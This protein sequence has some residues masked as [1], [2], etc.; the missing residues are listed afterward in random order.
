MCVVN[1][2]SV[3]WADFYVGCSCGGSVGGGRSTRI[4]SPYPVFRGL[5]AEYRVVWYSPLASTIYFCRLLA[6]T[7]VIHSLLFRVFLETCEVVVSIS[8]D[9]FL[10]NYDLVLF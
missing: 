9:F 1:C 10:L 7:F 2:E 5:L 4:S 3:G 8:A 6:R